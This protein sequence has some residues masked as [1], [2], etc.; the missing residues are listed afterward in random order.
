MNWLCAVEDFLD[1]ANDV[2]GQWEALDF[3]RQT[4]RGWDISASHA[5]HGGIQM[6]ECRA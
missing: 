3:E 2:V 1:G 4:V 6:V 5:E